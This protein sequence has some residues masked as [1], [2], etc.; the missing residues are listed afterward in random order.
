LRRIKDEYDETVDILTHMND[1]LVPA[2][3]TLDQTR[4]RNEELLLMQ[5]SQTKGEIKKIASLEHDLQKSLSTAQRSLRDKSM[6]LKD[7][8]NEYSGVM[9]DR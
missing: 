2:E 7:L 1:Q 9:M 6:T 5:S 3:H 8:Q 4:A